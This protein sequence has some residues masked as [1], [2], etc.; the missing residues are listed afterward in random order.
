MF[1]SVHLEAIYF[2]YSCYIIMPQIFIEH[3]SLFS[4]EQT[5]RDK[6]GSISS[7]SEDLETANNVV[8]DKSQHSN[9]DQSSL[10]DSEKEDISSEVDFEGEAEIARK[11][12][13]NLI[14]SSAKEVLPSLVDGNPPSKV[15]KE[16][17]LDSPKKSSDMSDKVTDGPGKL[18]DS[19]TSILKQTD[20]EDDL[21]RT[22]FIGNLPFD[23][24][25]EEV[26]QRFSGFGEVLSFVPVL[27]QV[28]KYGLYFFYLFTN[29]SLCSFFF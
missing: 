16:P 24:D 25:N 7:D 23:I 17:D 12:L 18:S 8:H 28:T 9:K 6:E 11:V 2:N 5:E 26:K 15:N 21:K 4:G 27:H 19:K 3:V 14:T 29:M 22:V 1:E 20:E 13:E 10:E